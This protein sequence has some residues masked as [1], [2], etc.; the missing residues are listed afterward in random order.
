MQLPNILPCPSFAA[1]SSLL[2]AGQGNSF[3]WRKLHSLLGV[4]PIGAF[5][6]EHLLSNFEALKGPAAYA[7]QVKFPQYAAAGSRAGVGLHLSAHPLSRHLRRLYLAARQVERGLLPLGV[8]IG[9]MCRSAGP[10]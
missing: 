9:C 7:A 1:V 4:I 2:R 3:L 8:A 6:V 10:G 5:L